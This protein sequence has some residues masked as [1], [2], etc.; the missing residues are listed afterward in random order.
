MKLAVAGTLA[1]LILFLADREKQAGV[2][3]QPEGVAPFG[4]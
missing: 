4:H 3:L 2:E 1:F